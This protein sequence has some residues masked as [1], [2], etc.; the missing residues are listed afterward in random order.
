[1]HVVPSFFLSYK[2]L[3]LWRANVKVVSYGDETQSN[4][5]FVVVAQVIAIVQQLQSHML[6]SIVANIHH[7][8]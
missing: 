2:S 7:I 4:K 1:M 8:I 3:Q 6:S 5:G